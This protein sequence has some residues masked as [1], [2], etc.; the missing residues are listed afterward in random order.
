MHT[1]RALLWLRWRLLTSRLRHR[2]RDLLQQLTNIVGPLVKLLLLLGLL[3]GFVLLLGGGA[4]GGWFLARNPEETEFAIKICRGL[5][6]ATLVA[7]LVR[8][9]L[10][11]GMSMDTAERLLLLPIHRHHLRWLHYL[12]ELLDPLLL[13]LAAPW[14][15]LPIGLAI[16]GQP[17]AALRALLGSGLL[18]AVLAAI[19]WG[20]ASLLRLLLLDRRRSDWLMVVGLLLIV[21]LSVSFALFDRDFI[22]QTAPMPA[23][24]T[25]TAVLQIL[26]WLD[27]PG[28]LWLLGVLGPAHHAALP[29]LGLAF[30]GLLSWKVAGRA[31]DRALL[32]VSTGQRT[33]RTGGRWSFVDQPGLTAAAAAVADAQLRNL[34]RSVLGK[35]NLLGGPLFILVAGVAIPAAESG[36]RAQI[37]LDLQIGFVGLAWGLIS[38][39]TFSFNSLASDGPGLTQQALLP[40]TARDLLRGKARTF[41][42]LSLAVT[43]L[44]LMV[45]WVLATPTLARAP[46]NLLTLLLAWFAV[47]RLV[48]PA[49]AYIS[50][51]LPKKVDLS[52]F[53]KKGQ[54]HQL[55]S[56]LGLLLVAFLMLIPTLPLLLANWLWHSPWSGLALLAA[57]AALTWLLAKPL[58]RGAERLWLSRL[59]NL[60][61]VTQRDS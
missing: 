16:A 11:G 56:F 5:L 10:P 51:L 49:A 53:G 47:S 36:W 24:E 8:P 39:S 23:A 27:P 32:A 45:G 31:Y 21:S 1:L 22:E 61:S 3:Q 18:L 54:P 50:L 38:Q 57:V 20:A 28:E 13:A 55:A 37:G 34:W 60:L 6:A 43:L 9:F 12:T 42:L 4:L 17:L 46:L 7:V 41:D 35:V 33:R 29:L 40:I 26:K 30:L 44:G 2:P 14:I 48:T 52:S 25:K 19:S 58:W 59:E 15:G